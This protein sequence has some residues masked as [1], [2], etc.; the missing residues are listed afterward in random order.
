[1]EPSL[2]WLITNKT[3]RQNAELVRPRSRDLARTKEEGTD[4]TFFYRDS[5]LLSFYARAK[6]ITVRRNGGRPR[7]PGDGRQFA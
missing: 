4:S 5:L 6:Q 7:Y 1:M 3:D 2:N